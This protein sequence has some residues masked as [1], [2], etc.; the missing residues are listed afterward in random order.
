MWKGEPLALSASCNVCERGEG[1]QLD[2]EEVESAGYNIEG[3]WRGDTGAK[4]D[5]GVIQR[6]KLGEG[7]MQGVN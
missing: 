3:G 7:V 4:P 2:K 6:G 1:C 5:E